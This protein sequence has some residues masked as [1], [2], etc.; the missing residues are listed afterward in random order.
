MPGWTVFRAMTS[1]RV[2]GPTN[3]G[4]CQAIAAPSTNFNTVYTVL[5]K[6]ES[7]FQRLGQQVVILTC[8]EALY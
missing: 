7:M 2:Y 3:I 5:E 1:Y 8:N 4:Y 6:A